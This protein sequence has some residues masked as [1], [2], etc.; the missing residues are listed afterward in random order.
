M[1]LIRERN[2]MFNSPKTNTNI[3]F[4]FQFKKE[5]SRHGQ[6]KWIMFSFN[7]SWLLPLIGMFF[8]ICSTQETMDEYGRV[9]IWIWQTH[10][11]QIFSPES[12]WNNNLC[13]IRKWKITPSPRLMI[14]VLGLTQDSPTLG[15]T[16]WFW[17]L[18]QILRKNWP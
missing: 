4:F 8:V 9:L 10:L 1:T 18:N 12:S 14:I 7:K 6:K 11:T 15:F 2:K 13:T 16:I 5:S 17:W 3:Y